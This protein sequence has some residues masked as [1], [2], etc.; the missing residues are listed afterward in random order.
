MAG[1][2]S[3]LD[4]LPLSPEEILDGVDFCL[5]THIHP[6]HFT[7]EYLPKE[8]PVLV[9]SEEDRREAEA[10]G[11]LNV[12]AFNGDTMDI[13][14]VRITRVPAVH[15][16][17][18]TIVAWMG[19]GSGYILQGEDKVL[20]LAGDTVYCDAVEETLRRY[21]PDVVAVN[22]CAATMPE[23]RLI[24]DMADVEAVCQCAPDA[25][26][27]ATHLDSVNHALL[28]SDAVRAY[29]QARGL[30]QVRVP[31]KGETISI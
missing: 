2:R 22:C 25:L 16:D 31:R 26:V 17:N 19:P 12:S 28:T 8:T 15:G 1:I 9:Q 21:E 7:P 3:P 10:M 6:D 13:G 24:M 30:S 20:Y 29:V 23:G 11:F 14:T 4:D 18:E 5:V 27:I